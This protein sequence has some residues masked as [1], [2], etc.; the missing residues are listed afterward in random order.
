MQFQYEYDV[1]EPLVNVEVVG[2]Q[3][4]IPDTWEE[5]GQDEEFEFLV[6]DHEGSEIDYEEFKPDLVRLAKEIRNE[7]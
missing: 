4:Y 2:Y 7:P 6:T 1:N 5:E 3:P